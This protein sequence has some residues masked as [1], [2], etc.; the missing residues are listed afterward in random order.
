M[1][2]ITRDILAAPQGDDVAAFDF[3]RNDGR[4]SLR[5]QTDFAEV[6]AINK[7]LL[8]KSDKEKTDAVLKDAIIFTERLV[9][10]NGQLPGAAFPA[11]YNCSGIL[12]STLIVPTGVRF[13][14]ATTPDTS[15]FVSRAGTPPF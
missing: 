11:C 3:E 8:L 7:I 13:P 12:S 2:E 4:L 1:V 5:V 15:K 14:H 6:V 10:G 9:K